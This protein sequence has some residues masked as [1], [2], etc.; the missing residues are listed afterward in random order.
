M[1]V[2]A[3]PAT[4]PP[5]KTL[6]R[7][8]EKQLELNQMYPFNALPVALKQHKLRRQSVTQTIVA[9]PVLQ[10]AESPQVACAKVGSAFNFDI[11]LKTPIL[12][13]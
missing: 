10:Q 1:Q 3:G 12:K 11:R 5:N 7:T 13:W 6:L 8:R 2:K 9:Q 4:A